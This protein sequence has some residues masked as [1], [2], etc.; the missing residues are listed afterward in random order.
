M[1]C[2]GKLIASISR[3]TL[4]QAAKQGLS[5][6]IRF[7]SASMILKLA[8]CFRRPR[9]SC[10]FDSKQTLHHTEDML[11][12]TANRR[13]CVFMFLGFVVLAFAHLLDLSR[14]T[15]DLVT[16]PLPLAT[17]TSSCLRRGRSR[18]SPLPREPVQCPGLRIC[19]PY[20]Q[21]VRCCP[22]LSGVQPD[23]AFCPCMW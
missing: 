15:V 19:A 2:H 16:E 6:R 17:T 18:Q 9:V 11:H 8:A 20:S 1:I 10:L 4:N 23:R 21:C 5:M 3:D 14:A 7:A 13:F 22:S 12:L